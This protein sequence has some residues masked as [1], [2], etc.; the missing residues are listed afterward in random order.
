MKLRK[1]TAIAILSYVLALHRPDGIKDFIPITNM[2]FAYNLSN[3]ETIIEM[4]EQ[5]TINTTIYLVLYFSLL[6]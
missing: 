6:I 3:I 2:S 5:E 4:A 1:N